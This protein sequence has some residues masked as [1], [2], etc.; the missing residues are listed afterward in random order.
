VPLF[1][2]ILCLLF[3]TCHYVQAGL[4]AHYDFAD[5]DLLDN[6]VG[7]AHT[8]QPMRGVQPSLSQVRLNTLEGTAVFSGGGPLAPWL[9]A[10][11]LLEVDA[12][13]VSFWFR[14]EQVDQQHKIVGLFST[15]QN[16]K[17]D[18]R[19]TWMV[20]SDH[21]LG[22]GLDLF[23]RRSGNP[24]AGAVHAPGVWQHVVVRQLAKSASEP[25]RLEMTVTPL[26]GELGDPLVVVKDFPGRLDQFVLG[27]NPQRN[28][29]Y[30]MEMAN[31]KIFDD[32]GVSLSSLFGEGP[33]TRSVEEVPL[34]EIRERLVQLEATAVELEAQL[35]ALPQV[36]DSLQL[37]AYGYH[38][39]YLPALDVLPEAP[40]WV[41][42]LEATLEHSFNELYLIP[43]ADRRAVDMP[44]YG[45]PQRFRILAENKQGETF[46]LAD[47]RE[48]D[49]P[50]PGRFPA[51]FVGV[52]WSLRKIRLEVYRGAVEGGREFFALD[53]ALVRADFFVIEA[54]SVTASSSF[55]SPP[56]WSTEYLIDQK[57][58][59]GLPVLRSSEQ[60]AVPD[61]IQQ[62][63]QAPDGPLIVELDLGQNS[64]NV[65]MITLFPAQ[66][67][68]GIIVPGFGFP[69]SVKV[70]LFEEAPNGGRRQKRQVSHSDLL[71]PGNNVFR[72][73][74]H[75]LP[76]RWLRFTF[77]DFPVH[78]GRATFAL[79][80]IAVWGKWNP[81]GEGAL[82]TVRQDA[83]QV[84]GYFQG[85]N[86]GLANGSQVW[87]LHLWL[88]GLV[89]RQDLSQ[90]MAAVEG[91]RTQLHE[92]WQGFKQAAL[93][94]GGVLLLVLFGGGLLVQF[95][96][97]LRVMLKL[98]HRITR[99]LHDEVGS[100]LGSIALTC[101]SLEQVTEDEALREELGEL[102]LVAREAC[103]SLRE[104][105]WV[106]DQRR[107]RLPKLLAKLME[108]AERVLNRMEL[109]V[110][111]PKDCPDVVVPLTFKRHLI[112]FF[113]EV[114]HNC[115]RHSQ[116]T[117]VE[118]VAMVSATHFK[119]L[120]HDNGCGFAPDQ[121]VDGWGLDSLRKR[122]MEMGGAMELESAPG[123]G[124][125]I[126]L[127]IPL[128]TLLKQSDH[129]YK[130]SN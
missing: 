82:V 128:K 127:K 61:Y 94:W 3:L 118:L 106:I 99:D 97:R 107:I 80:E 86:D 90:R 122:A 109:T 14:T 130:T 96:Y 104:V 78:D 56:F 77:D 16:T 125:T 18:V 110:E 5:G 79:G 102:S 41:V 98:K 101:E 1:R 32:T 73:S 51:R 108:R 19:G 84:V 17:A 121:V 4:V 74:G 75:S 64:E 92:R 76:L 10:E 50:N 60:A 8:L 91:L 11:G 26:D 67:P 54:Q 85:L 117:K 71:N 46:V 44:V 30:Q 87:P 111:L 29:A 103:V 27:I 120:V 53:E 43:A 57:T 36:D 31:V 39:D 112:M 63:D 66:P 124:T 88:D 123:E 42:E 89:Q 58:S 20:Y 24:E 68:E 22:G 65:N 9:E 114:V 62:F 113:K 34:F 35:A 47:W 23:E 28:F 7:P 48:R 45:F 119:L 126:V 25:P 6:E 12:F 115:A 13:T 33:Q 69:G 116:A 81:L 72:I 38:S 100:S 37:D 93:I 52:G 59:L 129:H 83:E 2:F 40:R 105:V 49:Y 70:N 21:L 55:E 95:F 15:A